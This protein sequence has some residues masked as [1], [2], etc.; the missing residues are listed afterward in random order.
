MSYLLDI[1]VVDLILVTRNVIDVERTGVAT[2]GPFRFG[3]R[4]SVP[5]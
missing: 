2:L 5:Q 4:G 3:T 1:N